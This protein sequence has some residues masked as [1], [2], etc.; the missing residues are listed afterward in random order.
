VSHW[1][2]ELEDRFLAEL[3]PADAEALARLGRGKA[4]SDLRAKILAGASLEGRFDRFAAQT[5]ELLVIDE[6]RAKALLDGI[7]RAES[8]EPSPLPGIDLFHVDGGPGTEDAITGFV[9]IPAGAGFP[10][11]EHL[12]DEA[13][14]VIQGSVEDTVSGAIHRPGDVARMAAGTAHGLKVRPG[15]DFVYLSVVQRGVKI[16]DAVFRPDDL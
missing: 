5:A 14:L 10:E 7:G 13:V 12:G 16:G 11:H 15:A 3:D 6:A 1:E 9:R 4:P 8:W 2:D